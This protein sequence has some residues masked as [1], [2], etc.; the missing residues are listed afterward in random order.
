MQERSTP[1]TVALIF[2]A[3]FLLVGILGFIPAIT[4][5]YADM[6]FAGHGSSAKLFGLFQVSVL[7]NIVHLAFGLAGLSLAKSLDGA[8]TYLLGGG[9]VYLVLFLYGLVAHGGTGANF[10]PVNTA[11]NILHVGLGVGMIALG[12]VAARSRRAQAPHQNADASTT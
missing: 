6:S 1:Q 7:H 5:H 4:T 12:L 10:I 9:A 2:G 8:R 11:D 3:T